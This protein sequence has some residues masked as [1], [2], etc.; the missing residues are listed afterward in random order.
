M[1]GWDVAEGVRDLHPDVA[2]VYASGKPPVRSRLVQ[3]GVFVEKP[4]DLDRVV[5]PGQRLCGL[6][7]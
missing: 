2:V 3:G 5:D 4:F 7:A 6:H 1:S